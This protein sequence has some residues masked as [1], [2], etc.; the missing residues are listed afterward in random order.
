MKEQNTYIWLKKK[1]YET[2]KEME[3][4]VNNSCL[5]LNVLKK[6]IITDSRGSRN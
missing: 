3:K 6:I 5:N 4:N 1:K 2:H